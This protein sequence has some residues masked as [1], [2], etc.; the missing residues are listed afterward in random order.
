[1]GGDH[2]PGDR[3]GYDGGSVPE[4]GGRYDPSPRCR[5]PGDDVVEG[6]ARRVR[7]HPRHCGWPGPSLQ[8]GRARHLVRPEATGGRAGSDRGR[9]PEA[10]RRGYYGRLLVYVYV[11]GE[12]F[13]ERLLETGHARLYESTF[14][15]RA[16][17]E[18]AERT[19]RQNAVG[20]W[21]YDA[22][23]TTTTTTTTTT[24]TTTTTT[25]TG[26]PTTTTTTT[27]SSDLPP[28]PEDGDYDCSHFDSQE[29]AQTVLEQ[30]PSDPHRLDADD[31][32][33][34]CESLSA[35]KHALLHTVTAWLEI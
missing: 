16:A 25:T 5:H 29:Q 17:F 28:L 22:P 27:G 18:Q 31:D 21:D 34:A 7:G 8:L 26:T 33:I 19:A 2:R 3:W 9:Y 14:S 13:N 10:D 30:D 11:D 32:G 1:M 15:K 24:S 23:T 35:P 4:R 12:N 20:L 6:I